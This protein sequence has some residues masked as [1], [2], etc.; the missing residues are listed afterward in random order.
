MAT[1]PTYEE[2]VNMINTIDDLEHQMNEALH[3]LW[4]SQFEVLWAKTP[5]QR[6]IATQDVRSAE[7]VFKKLRL[8]EVDIEAALKIQEAV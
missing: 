1:I 6:L 4:D 5:E 2:R 7:A 3:C 8:N